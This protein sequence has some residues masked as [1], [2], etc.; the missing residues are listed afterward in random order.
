MNR[1][2]ETFTVCLTHDVDRVRKTYQYI[3]HDLRQG[4]V[5]NIPIIFRQPDPYWNFDTIM[6]IEEKYKVRSTFF[7]LHESIRP[8]LLSLKSWILAFGRYKFTE[9]EVARTIKVL[10]AGGW[11]IGLHGSY[12]SYLN[13]V[14]LKREKECLESVLGKPV[15]GVRQHYL[16]LIIP[17]TWKIHENSGF[18]Y[19]A[20]FGMKKD[21]GFLE[22]RYGPFI[23][24]GRKLVILPLALMDGNLFLKA[25]D[26][27]KVAWK[28]VVD[29]IDL[30]EKKDAC[31]SVLWHQRVFNDNEFPGYT[32]IY[33]KIIAEC[34]RRGARFLTCRQVLEKYL[35]NKG[36]YQ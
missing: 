33:Q 16:N 29:L 1:R 23:Y 30:A 7:F 36:A 26:D 12:N 11:E 6:R 35:L 5:K 17:E 21:I 3:T 34:Q 32:D 31:L 22:D 18:S 27:I 9:P 25:N 28:L 4:K 10:D 20:T 19:D 13:E 14:L 2:D 8:K 24:P 15:I